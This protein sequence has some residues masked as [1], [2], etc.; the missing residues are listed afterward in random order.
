MYGVVT[1]PDHGWASLHTAACLAGAAGLLAGFVGIEA[2]SPDPMVPLALFR[3]RRVAG[4]NAVGLMFAAAVISTFTTASLYMQHVL[5][6]TP[7][8]AGAASLIASVA[9]IAAASQV[10]RLV[11]RFGVT[12]VLAAGLTTSLLGRLWLATARVHG[13]YPLPLLP[14]LLAIGIGIGLTI[15]PVTIVAVSGARAERADVA[16][17]LLGACQQVGAALGVATLSA[18][19]TGR[20]RAYLHS[21]CGPSRAS[22]ALVSGFDAAFLSAAAFIIAALLVTVAA[23]RTPQPPTNGSAPAGRRSDPPNP[24][25]PVTRPHR[26]AA[27]GDANPAYF[28]IRNDVR[29]AIGAARRLAR[30]IMPSD[31]AAADR[32]LDTAFPSEWREDGWQRFGARRGRVPRPA[33]H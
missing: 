21:H 1:S 3:Q 2:R 11:T 15:V 30:A 10:G 13:S 33:G 4:A 22:R 14:G 23:L 20:A 16:A 26:P 31:R 5:G 12:I 28:G 29:S 9:M 25:P 17:A 19:A 24:R 27:T 7:F 6:Y 32:L 8:R 18:V